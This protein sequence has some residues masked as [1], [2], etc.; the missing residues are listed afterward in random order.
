MSVRRRG[1]GLGIRRDAV[2]G[3]AERGTCC[4]TRSFL[5][6]VV[7]SRLRFEGC[8]GDHIALHQRQ[9]GGRRA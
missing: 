7:S 9:S 3:S 5:A 4:V 2:R 6:A 8:P 1:G